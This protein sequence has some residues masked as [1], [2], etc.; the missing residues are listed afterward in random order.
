MSEISSFFNF[1]FG[2]VTIDPA[3]LRKIA[4]GASSGQASKDDQKASEALVSGSLFKRYSESRARSRDK[5]DDLLHVLLECLDRIA[6][7]DYF[8]KAA[9]IKSVLDVLFGLGG[10]VLPKKL[11]AAAAFL[12]PWVAGAAKPGESQPPDAGEKLRFICENPD[13]LITRAEFDVNFRDTDSAAPFGNM[14]SAFQN[15][16]EVIDEREYAESIIPDRFVIS[17]E[18][19]R[20]V[21]DSLQKYSFFAAVFRDGFL[22]RRSELADLSENYFVAEGL[23]S[24]MSGPD[25]E[26]FR[27][28]ARE[29]KR[30]QKMGQLFARREYSEIEKKYLIPDEVASGISSSDAA[31]SVEAVRAMRNLVSSG[32]LISR[33]EARDYINTDPSYSEKIRSAS[34]SIE[35]YCRMSAIVKNRVRPQ[36]FP[37]LDKIIANLSGQQIEASVRL[38]AYA[39]ALKSFEVPWKPV[40]EKIITAVNATQ[41][42][43]RV[44]V[45]FMGV[46]AFFFAGMAGIDTVHVLGAS[47]A[48][49]FLGAVVAIALTPALGMS[50]EKYLIK[51]TRND[52]EYRDLLLFYFVVGVI[53]GVS[54]VILF[55][56][57]KCFLLGVV[58][59]IVSYF[60]FA[61]EDHARVYSKCIG[62]IDEVLSGAAKRRPE[63]QKKE[64]G[65]GSA[66]KTED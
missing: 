4:A 31:V 58:S 21:F 46:L 22:V 16:A 47:K 55:S 28:A 14:E 5:G 56:P 10:F 38:A 60:A 64:P 39:A 63:D 41:K 13:L 59:A 65:T 6:E 34:R 49:E 36:Y 30:I 24:A 26:K 43:D 51:K 42:I 37:M 52:D 15:I 3:Y 17:E 62:R 32:V 48:T 20:G 11:D 12:S 61:T 29:F 2:P 8:I 33:E 1:K 7:K 25:P 54:G 44:Y 50:L 66:K 9:R 57:V 23:V 18:I 27:E 53:G 40:D 19:A 35:N 45:C